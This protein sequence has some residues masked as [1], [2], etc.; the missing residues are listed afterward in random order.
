MAKAPNS[1]IVSS[2]GTAARL[3]LLGGRPLF[4]GED[5]IAYDQ[6]LARVFAAVKPADVIEEIWIQDIADLSWEVVRLRR[7]KAE[8]LTSSA[9]KGL[10][11]VLNALLGDQEAQNLTQ[12]WAAQ[13]PE[14]LEEVK[15]ILAGADMT[16]DVVMVQTL[17]VV[18]DQFERVD[19]MIMSAEMRRNAALREIDRHRSALA[20]TLRR[21]TNDVEEAEF[22][23]VAL[24]PAAAEGAA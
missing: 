16:M 4:A 17:S 11:R 7:L 24:Q 8:L 12:Q 22:E 9:H 21:A 1:T 23:I 19:R 15:G 20:G 5:E 14:A 6:L 2:A 3:S 13:I 18:I 10:R